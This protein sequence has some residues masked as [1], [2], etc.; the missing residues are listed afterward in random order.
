ME[1]DL[2]TKQ[3]TLEANYEYVYGYK[4]EGDEDE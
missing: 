2:D 1:Q 4:Y 3:A